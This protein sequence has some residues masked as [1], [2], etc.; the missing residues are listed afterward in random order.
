[1]CWKNVHLLITEISIHFF[2]VNFDFAEFSRR[3]RVGERKSYE[4]LF[5]LD[6]HHVFILLL[7]V[8]NCLKYFFFKV[9]W[10]GSGKIHCE[11]ST[12]IASILS[13][14]FLYEAW[15]MIIYYSL[16]HPYAVNVSHDTMIPPLWPRTGAIGSIHHIFCMSSG[17]HLVNLIISF[18]ENLTNASYGYV[19][20]WWHDGEVLE[21]KGWIASWARISLK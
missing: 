3:R 2:C 4:N 18:A 20:R 8:W 11:T 16:C 10:D 6:R 7:Q 9:E 17:I 13:F 21:Q 15:S 12:K 19:H 14:Q 1:M 5:F